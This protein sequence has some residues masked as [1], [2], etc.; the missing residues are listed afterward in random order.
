VPAQLRRNLTRVAGVDTQQRPAPTIPTPAVAVIYAAALG[1]LIWHL[2]AVPLFDGYGLFTNGVDTKVYRGGARAVLDGRHLYDAPAYRYWWFTY[3]PFA[4][5]TMLPLALVSQAHAIRLMEVAT[6]VCLFLFIVLTLRGL[7]F[8]CDRRFWATAVAATIAAT[9]LEPVHTTIW[10]GQVNLILAVLIVGCL[11]LPV[12]RWRGTG[13]GLAAGIKLTPILF[14]AYLVI[15]RQFRAALTAAAVFAATVAVGLV[16]LRDQAWNYWR[17][18]GDTAHIG[19]E[20]APANQSIHGLLA[21]LGVLGVWQAPTW[22]WVPLG[23]VAGCVGLYAAWRAQQAG[24][25]IL[26]ITLVGMT[27]CAIAPFS[28]GHH[29]IWIVPLLLLAVLW[30]GDS[31][32]CGRPRTWVRWLVPAAI[33]VGGLAW[34]VQEPLGGRLVWRTGSFRVFWTPGAHGWQAALAVAGSAS[35]LVIFAGSVAATLWWSGRARRLEDAS[36]SG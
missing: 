8:R 6:V 16:V 26:A 29:W 31:V 34:R 17:N 30:A 5:L 23:V 9:L 14:V 2:F 4:A 10:Q 13:V 27:T 18:L 32:R 33:A 19:V 11:T 28:W 21:R 35:Y 36:R 20:S 7:G 22:L 24:A 3:P 25:T 1:A 12:G 15:T